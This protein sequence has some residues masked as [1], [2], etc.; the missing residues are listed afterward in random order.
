MSQ[1]VIRDGA[2]AARLTAVTP[3]VRVFVTPEGRYVAALAVAAGPAGDTDEEAVRLLA[4]IVAGK[5]DSN[6]DH[7]HVFRERLKVHAAPEAAE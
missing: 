4:D 7:D 1:D 6:I 3:N 2:G 5:L